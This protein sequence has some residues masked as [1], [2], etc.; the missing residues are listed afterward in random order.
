M[1]ELGVREWAGLAAL[2]FGVLLAFVFL[3][4]ASSDTGGRPPIEHGDAPRTPTAVPITAEPPS[5]LPTPELWDISFASI[6]DGEETVEGGRVVDTLDLA[7]E[8][9]PFPDYRDDSWNVTARTTISLG[10][11]SSVFTLEYDC[12]IR[13]FIDD[14]EVTSADNP[15]GPS[16]LVV[17]FP[18]G[19][20]RFDIRIEATDTG[21][22]FRLAYR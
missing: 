17:T 4:P 2:V 1:R 12:A 7:F 15:D 20:G 13:V 5:L 9:A 10:V 19:R 11:G 18:H 16:N 22:P 8:N 3:D 14:R 6:R 21:G